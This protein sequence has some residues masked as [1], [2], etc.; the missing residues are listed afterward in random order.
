MEKFKE[1]Q[2][3]VTPNEQPVV[4]QN[5]VDT[6]W[7]ST[8]IMLR[9]FLRLQVA[10]TRTLRE[11]DKFTTV[12]MDHEWNFMAFVV[13]ISE[14]F[15]RVT[16]ALSGDTYPTLSLVYPVVRMIKHSVDTMVLPTGPEFNAL[17]TYRVGY[18]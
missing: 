16:V 17:H 3:I 9:S 10:L 6:R 14:P 4:L 8:I 18:L 1:I 12:I 2:L 7:N 5:D 15:R 11:L 13:S